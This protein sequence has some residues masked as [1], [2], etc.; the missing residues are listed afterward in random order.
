[1]EYVEGESLTKVI[2]RIGVAGMLDWKHAYRVAVHIGQALDF[3][4]TVVRVRLNRLH[5][6]VDRQHE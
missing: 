1:M 2:Q 6:D 4:R 5:F 3:A